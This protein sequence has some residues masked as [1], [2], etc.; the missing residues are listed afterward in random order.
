MPSI[1][2]KR[3]RDRRSQQRLR[4]RKQA[5]VSEL[6]ERV[7]F[8][9]EHHQAYNTQDAYLREIKGLRQQNMALAQRQDLLRSLVMSWDDLEPDASAD[10]NRPFVGGSATADAMQTITQSPMTTTTPS[11]ADTSVEHSETTALGLRRLQS[12]STPPSASSTTSTTP[13]PWSVL[14][15][16]DD[17]WSDM[18]SVVGCFWL[19]YPDLI[20]DC[21]DTPDSPLDILFGSKVNPLADMIYKNSQRRP[22]REPERMATGWMSY[23]LARWLINPC[24]ATFERLPPFMRPVGDQL[25]IPHPVALNLVPWPTARLNL[26]RLWPRYRSTS[27]DM[28]AL[29]ACCLRVRWPW[30]EGVLERDEDNALVLREGFKRMITGSEDGWTITRDFVDQ[31]PDIFVGMHLDSILY[32]FI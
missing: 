18:E 1:E 4:D 27:R 17:D 21:P 31:Y 30:G 5:K 10:F 2:K 8:C 13:P 32:K 20:R 25:A 15:P 28:I 3:A 19:G 11:A 24:P 6:E 14:P 29:M 16:H 9:R 7:Q 12:D 22:L 26:I 23:H